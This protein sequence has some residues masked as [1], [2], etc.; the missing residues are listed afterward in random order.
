MNLASEKGEL[1]QLHIRER[2]ENTKSLMQWIKDSVIAQ[3]VAV[4]TTNSMLTKLF[5]MVSGELGSS[6]NLW[7]RW[8]RM[9]G[10]KPLDVPPLV[11]QVDLGKSSVS[12][13]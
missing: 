4:R 6:L 3:T 11:T 2:L 10:M 5:G 1:D 8:L 12:T 9:S 7:T 13:E